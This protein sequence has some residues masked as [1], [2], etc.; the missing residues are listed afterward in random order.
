MIKTLGSLAPCFLVSVS[1]IAQI[2]Y[3]GNYSATRDIDSLRKRYQHHINSQIDDLELP[4]YLALQYYPE[5]FGHEIRIVER[6]KARYPIMAGYSG[7][8]V[9][10]PRR[11]HRYKLVISPD[12]FVKRISL[13]KQVGVI[14]HEMAHFAYYRQRS[15]PGMLWWG[16]KYI[17]SRKF[18][19][20]FEKD[21]DKTAIDHG[22]GPQ[23]LELSMYM[24]HNE[25]I[26][27]LEQINSTG[28]H[29]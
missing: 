2:T 6:P 1:L 20:R 26:E 24:P 13:N 11:S 19:Y 23:L 5:L 29:D 15:T 14:G 12:S 16:L 25:V 17:T 21:A 22:L 3:P 4:A 28:N 7:W 18:R 27:Y 10:K 9:L 8:N